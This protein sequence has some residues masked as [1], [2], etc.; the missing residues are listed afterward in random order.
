MRNNLTILNS[1][2][3]IDDR[4]RAVMIQM[5]L[6]NPNVQFFTSV[7]FLI[8]IL[9]TGEAF[10]STRVEP[11]Q[12]YVEFNDF[13]SIFYLIIAIIYIFFIAFNTVNEIYLFIKQK[14]KYL[15][16]VYS[17]V[18]WC[19]LLCS[20]SGVGVYIA[21]YIEAR[22]LAKRFCQTNGL[23]YINLQYASL[24][25]DILTFLLGFC[26]FF[27]TIRVLRLFIIFPHVN[28]FIRTLR[29]ALKEMILFSLMFFLLF[30][31]FICL[32]YL[33]FVSKLKS[34]STILQTSGMLF[35]MLLL[36]FDVT[37]IQNA[38]A[39]LGPFV[40]TLF[41]YFVVFI[42]V[43]MFVTIITTNLRVVRKEMERSNGQYTPEVFSF[44]IRDLVKRSGLKRLT[45]EEK[46]ERIDEIMRSRYQTPVE[47]LPEKVNELFIQ[48]EKVFKQKKTIE[49]LI[50]TFCF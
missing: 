15:H 1:L 36:K 23:T 42:C 41:I 6:Y 45:D 34:S 49:H 4:S 3:W 35:E 8:E 37:D 27:G 25:N 5:N 19:I 10:S 16:R 44:V 30:F 13:S 46:Y 28:L 17:Y 2:S 20:W 11:I 48:L 33:L 32:F 12:M 7:T 9:E 29:R 50:F 14:M 40:F 47:Q 21:R 24:L 38:D 43:T 26:C 22:R 39:F 31:A 18:E